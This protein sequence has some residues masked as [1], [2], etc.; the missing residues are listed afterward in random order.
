METLTKLAAVQLGSNGLTVGMQGLGCMGMSEFYGVRN[1]D[2]SR[3]TIAR[4][5]DHGAT[6]IDTAGMY[7]DGAN[8]TLVGSALRSRR[9]QA[10][11][12]TKFGVTRGSDP[13]YFGLDNRPDYIRETCEASLR[14]LGVDVIDLYYMHRR[15]RA[16]PLADSI[17]AMAE[18]VQAGKVRHLGVSELDG[19]ELR[20]AHSIHPIAAIQSEWSLFSRDVEEGVVPVAAELGIAFVAYSPLGR[21]QLTDANQEPSDPTD[22][23]GFLPRFTGDAGARN[24][25]LVTKL[26]ALAGE[27]GATAAQLA[28]AWVHAR[29]GVHG[30]T[31]VPIPGTRRMERLDEN[32]AAATMTL[33]DNEL[34]TLDTLAAEVEG[35][36]PI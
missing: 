9:E 24:A 1:D 18:L 20:E 36:R 23:R 4:A 10:V 5:L 7:G 32:I 30:L 28:L 25:R 35:I 21:G 29:S 6:L 3:A 13:T 14:R 2:Q 26:R 34:A 19:H 31:V 8:E 33:N 22:I 16:V 11:I 17:G 15:D 12:A 27:R